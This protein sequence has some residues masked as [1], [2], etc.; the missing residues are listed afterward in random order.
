MSVQDALALTAIGDIPPA[1]FEGLYWLE[2][3]ANDAVGLKEPS[4][5]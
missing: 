5:H 2:Q 3:A 4:L 1:E